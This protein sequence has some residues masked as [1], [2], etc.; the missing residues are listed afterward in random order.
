MTLLAT[1]LTRPF[2][3]R[4][5]GSQREQAREIGGVVG[6]I[7]G[8]KLVFG[9]FNGAPWAYVVRTIEARGNVRAVSGPG[10]TWP[11]ALPSQLRIP[12]DHVMAG[13]GLSFVSRRVLPATGSDHVPVVVEVAVT[14]PSQCW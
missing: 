7:A 10:G 6:G 5:Y 8:A 4:P 3:H 9:D 14:D 2:P 11:S 1:H 12:I 13:P